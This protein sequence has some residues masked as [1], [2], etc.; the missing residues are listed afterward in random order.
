MSDERLK[1]Q[2]LVEIEKYLIRNGSSLTRWST[3]PYP[4]YASFAVGNKCLVDEEL[5][6]DIPQIQSELVTLKSSLTDEQLSVYNQIMT[7][8]E[9]DKGGVFFV[10]GYGG[11]GKT[12]LWKTLALS[13]RSREQIV[14]NVA[15]SG[16]ASLLM[17]GGRTAHS[18]FHIP[19]NLDE[20]S[21]CH[22]RPDGAVA[23]LL[24]HTRLIIWDEAPM[25]HRHAFEALDRTF[26]DVLVDKSNRQSDGL[27][28]GKVIVFGGDF[29]Q[30]LPVIPNGSRQEIV[31]ASLSSSYIW[32]QCKLLTL[33]KNMKLT[34]G[35]LQ[36]RLEETQKFAKWLLDIDEGKVGGD[37]DGV[38][39]VQI[40]SDL[41]ITDSF[42]PIESLIQFVYPSVLERYMDRDYCSEK[43]ILT[44]KNEVV[45]EI[46]DRLL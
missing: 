34:I 21:M 25:V 4:D 14:L 5:S 7:A 36:S 39:I 17:S 35:A 22:I 38:A 27:F 46:N 23:Y 10:Y 2:T 28:G 16:I 24:K 19:I 43:A 31:N 33:T 13:V 32:S 6:F 12:F 11:T 8:V 9:G 44:P 3:I 30:I 18:R 41:L 40:P 1:N 37:N 29:R 15:S 26:K 20:N 45:H 42:D